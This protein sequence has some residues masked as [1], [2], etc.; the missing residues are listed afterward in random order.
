MTR[1]AVSAAIGDGN[2]QVDHLLYQGIECSRGHHLLEALPSTL[3]RFRVVGEIFPEIVN[4]RH[5]TRSF[6]IVID[7]PNLDRAIGIFDR[8]RF[9]HVVAPKAQA[10]PRRSRERAAAHCS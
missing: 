10:V 4:V 6:D 1:S 2:S 8:S 9:A 7:G 5:A 3:E